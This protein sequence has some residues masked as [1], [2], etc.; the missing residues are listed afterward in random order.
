MNKLLKLF[1]LLC[2]VMILFSS[3]MTAS[4]DFGQKDQLTVYVLN[5]PDELYYLDLQT[6]EYSHYNNI[7]E[8]KLMDCLAQN[9]NFGIVY[10]YENQIIGDY[11][12]LK[13]G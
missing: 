7:A 8:E 2:V 10:H 5:P 6:Q 11:D 9:E 12:Q 3:I 4:A 1:L 13:N